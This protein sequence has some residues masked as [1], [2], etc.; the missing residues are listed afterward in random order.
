MRRPDGSRLEL[1][2][3]VHEA[4]HVVARRLV[5]LPT[6]WASAVP[7]VIT[8]ERDVTPLCQPPARQW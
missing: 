3:A 7:V 2:L 5:G 8:G 4:G 1:R 6:N